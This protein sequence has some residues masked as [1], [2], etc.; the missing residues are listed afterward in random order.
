MEVNLSW[1]SSVTN[2]INGISTANALFIKEV[3]T[4]MERSAESTLKE[5]KRKTPKDSGL[6][7][8]RWRKTRVRRKGRYVRFYRLYN[9]TPYGKHVKGKKNGRSRGGLG[10]GKPFS[11]GR[12]SQKDPEGYVQQI[13]KRRNTTLRNNLKKVIRKHYG[14][15]AI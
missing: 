13:V 15:K 1:G 5:L 4:T 3:N 9:T 12:V 7:E 2:F 10:P 14:A 11:K 6:L 8:S